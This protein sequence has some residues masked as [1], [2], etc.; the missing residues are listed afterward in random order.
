MFLLVLCQ[1]VQARVIWKGGKSTEVLLPQDPSA[2]NPVVY[3]DRRLMG[4]GPVHC[5]QSYPWA[6]GHGC[7]KKAG[8]AGLEE[9]AIKQFF[10]CLFIRSSLQFLGLIFWPSFLSWWTVMKLYQ[11]ETKAFLL[12][13]SSGHDIL[14]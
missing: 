13:F 8:W 2:S 10:P 6:G 4:K 5:D 12:K 11:H 1:C 9:E 7:Y 14:S 3:L